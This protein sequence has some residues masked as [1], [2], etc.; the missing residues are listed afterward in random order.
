MA[1]LLG[2]G[3]VVAAKR[4]ESRSQFVR[5]DLKQVFGRLPHEQLVSRRGA[6]DFLEF[7]TMLFGSLTLGRTREPLGIMPHAIRETELGCRL[8]LRG[9]LTPFLKTDERVQ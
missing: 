2:G 3:F 8:L 4:V 7:P 5:R 6:H 9:Q 1:Q